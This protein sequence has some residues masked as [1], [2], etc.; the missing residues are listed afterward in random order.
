MAD[1]ARSDG[2]KVLEDAQR[3]LDEALAK[4]DK[5]IE[6]HELSYLDDT[7]HGNIIRGWDGYADLKGKKDI[8]LK[9]VRPYTIH[10]KL[11]SNSSIP[12]LPKVAVVTE[13]APATG[14][15]EKKKAE[16]KTSIKASTAASK[17]LKLKVK[18]RK[19][20]DTIGS[21]DDEAAP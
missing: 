10:E 5:Q 4:M 2:I 21:E 20:K 12:P 16:S 14:G 13:P 9:K 3:K 1:P 11:F 8:L 19:L 17:N 15:D 18:K 7:A 6:E